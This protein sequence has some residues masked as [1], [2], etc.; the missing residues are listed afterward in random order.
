MFAREELPQAAALA[1]FLVLIVPHSA[2]TENLIDAGIISG[3]KAGA[4][5]INVARGGVLDEH[6]LLDALRSGRLAGAGLDVFREQPLP[7]DSPLWREPK[8]IITPLI[9]GMSNIYLDQAYPIV[10]DNLN[11]FLAGN[12]EA[13][14]NLVAH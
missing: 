6:A 5:L 2:A 13:M 1:D 3:M 9:G 14:S 7:A 12:N 8:V 4:Y 11:H 10:R